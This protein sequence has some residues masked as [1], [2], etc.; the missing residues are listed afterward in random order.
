M[1]EVKNYWSCEI[2]PIERSKVPDGGDGPLRSAVQNRFIEMFDEQAEVCSSGWGLTEEMKTRL[3]I[4]S[5]SD[6]EVL[7]KIDKILNQF[8]K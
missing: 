6:L 3:D 8:K 7:K 5:H 1:K 4:I 2:G